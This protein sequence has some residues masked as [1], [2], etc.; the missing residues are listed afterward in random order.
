MPFRIETTDDVAV[1]MLTRQSLDDPTAE[2]AG[3]Q[4]FRLAD[5]QGRPEVQ[6]DLGDVPY[7]SSMWLG[8]L[9]AC[10]TG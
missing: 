5:E 8:K 3:E 7:L 1:I 10:T 2:A 4:L 9:V 6:V